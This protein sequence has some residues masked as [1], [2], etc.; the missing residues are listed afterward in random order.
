MAV[1]TSSDHVEKAA[2]P[3]LREGGKDDLPALVRVWRSAVDATHQFLPAGDRDAIEAVLASDY[4]P[5]VRLTVAELDGETIAFAGTSGARLEML[6]VH[7]EL[8][9]RGIGSMLIEHV[10]RE[11][12]VIDVDVNEQNPAAVAFYTSKGFVTV[13]RSPVDE[14]GRPYPL[15]HLTRCPG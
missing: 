14:T 7:A 1:V 13:G 15:L 3:T 11:D 4:L 10:L 12:G 5:A 2:A 8:R 6:F 9:G